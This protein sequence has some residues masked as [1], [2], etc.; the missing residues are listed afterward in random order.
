VKNVNVAWS[1]ELIL[2][3]LEGKTNA[4]TLKFSGSDASHLKRIKAL[5]QKKRA[6]HTYSIFKAY[7]EWTAT[8]T[9]F[10][11]LSGIAS[12]PLQ[13]LRELHMAVAC[14]RKHS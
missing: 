5:K 8:T 2:D 14:A 12:T 6:G 7:G 13:A 4:C 9:E 3:Y 11:N 10:P 1:V